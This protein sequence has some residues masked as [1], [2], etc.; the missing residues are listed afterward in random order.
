MP[1]LDAT[2]VAPW[3]SPAKADTKDGD[4]AVVSSASA[5][6]LEKATLLDSTNINP[7]PA[8]AKTPCASSNSV[9]QQVTGHTDEHY[10]RISMQVPVWA[11]VALRVFIVLLRPDWGTML[12]GRVEVST[13]VTSFKRL[14]ECIYL[15]THDIPPY[16]GGVCHQAPLLVT[17]FQYIP[18]FATPFVFILTD[19]II[20][21]LFVSIAE[22]KR[23]LQLAEVWPEAVKVDDDVPATS[24]PVD[25]MGTGVGQVDTEADK[26]E[27]DAHTSAGSW[28]DPNEKHHTIWHDDPTKPVDALI[29]P[30]DVGS[31]YMFNPYAIIICLAKSTQSFSSLG[32]LAAIHFAIHGHIGMTV[33]SLATATYLSLYP[34][35]FLPLC[36]LLLVS[37]R[38]E[39]ILKISLKGI[40]LFIVAI[41][42]LLFSS[43]LLFGDWKF[44]ESTYG[45]IIFVTDLTPNIGLYWYFFIEM[46][47]QFRTFFLVV[48]HITTIIFTMPVTLRFNKHPLFVAFMLAG[49]SA[50][51]KSY[52][53]IAD[54][55]LFLSL[56]AIYPEVFKY[57]RNMFFAITA[58]AYA[59]LLGP[60]FFNLWVYSGAGNANF[61]YAITLVFSLAL[62]IYLV[63][64][65]F[66]MLRREWERL[67][68]GWRRMRYEVGQI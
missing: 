6:G 53:S 19:Y 14:N 57:A 20:A 29:V 59:T 61:F 47:D 17:L 54:T 65:S 26:A 67:H 62:V 27:I 68:P 63:D 15:H 48:F 36:I 2:V 56:S 23:T 4:A 39:S 31:L 21:R 58:L 49:F 13:P 7:S 35:I 52:P 30:E 24:T 37:S 33:L 9:Q 8:M 11:G 10:G 34:V 42:V 50:L 46:F 45:T 44:L 40:A 25:E 66:A 1:R 3:H 51:F 60:L 16:D 5:N 38:K 28:H 18:S 41:G 32:I 43:F 12:A 55:A 22:Y 64:L